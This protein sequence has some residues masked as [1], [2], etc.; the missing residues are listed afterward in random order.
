MTLAGPPGGRFLLEEALSDYAVSSSFLERDLVHASSQAAPIFQFEDPV[1][2]SALSLNYRGHR[3]RVYGVHPC[4]NGCLMC[5]KVGTAAAGSCT[6]LLHAGV[7]GVVPFNRADMISLST[8]AMNSSTICR[9]GIW[10]FF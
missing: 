5:H 8:T 9:L 10:C 6:V 2:G 3:S 4:E 7:F 1:Y